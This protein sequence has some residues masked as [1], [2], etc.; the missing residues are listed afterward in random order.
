MPKI[1]EHAIEMVRGCKCK[2]GCGLHRDY[3]LDKDIVCWGLENLLTQRDS[4]W[5]ET[6]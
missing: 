5:D 2:D 4:P 6:A 3:R 1:I